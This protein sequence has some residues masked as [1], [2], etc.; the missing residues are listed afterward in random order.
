MQ[1]N[2][3]CHNAKTLLSFLEKEGIAVMKCP[4]QSPDTNPV[5]NVWKIIG[6]KAQNRNQAIGLMSRVFAN[7]PG[8]RG[9][10]SVRVIPMTLKIVFDDS[11][12][13]T[14]HYKVRFKG[15]V[16]QPSERSSTLSYTSV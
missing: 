4:S 11:L 7:G 15:K 10:I 2:A 9:S 8:D 14:Q 6:E 1:D 5:K 12:L 16:E 13:N 3:P